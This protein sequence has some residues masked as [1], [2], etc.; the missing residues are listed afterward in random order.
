[1]ASFDTET[2]LVDATD[3]GGLVEVLD[4]VAGAPGAW[5]NVEPDVD[6]SLRTEVSGLFAWFSARGAQV[7]VGTFV[8]GTSRD[9]PSIGVDHGSGRG[10]GDRLRLGLWPAPGARNGTFSNG[11]AVSCLG[12]G[13][14]CAFGAI[15]IIWTGV[16]LIGQSGP[17]ARKMVLVTFMQ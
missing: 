12:R 10:A 3:P 14:K 16:T 9:V 11:A 6:D 1:M 2:F 4:E 8:A 5:V 17:N 7:P 15:M 13:R